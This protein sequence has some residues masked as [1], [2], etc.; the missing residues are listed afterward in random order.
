[1]TPSTLL[2]L[3][4]SHAKLATAVAA[5]AAVTASG[6]MAVAS[7][8]TTD[9]TH[10]AAGLARAAEA[11]AAAQPEA[12]DEST[13]EVTLPECPSDVKNHGAYVSSVAKTPRE[14][15]ADPNAHGKLVA[16]AAQSDCGKPAGGEDAEDE[17]EGTGDG[18]A[19]KADDHATKHPTGKP[20]TTGKPEG[21]GKPETTGRAGQHGAPTD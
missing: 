10:A 2:A 13:D 16:A 6:G 8:V 3:L 14:E 4:T 20:E 11:P 17:G 5:T 18:P 21:V 1:M 19:D 15:G 7:A 9:N 12:G